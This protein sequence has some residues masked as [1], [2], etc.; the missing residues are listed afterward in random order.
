MLLNNS[1][2]GKFFPQMLRQSGG[3]D[4]QR[5]LALSECIRQPWERTAETLAVRLK[6]QM[7]E[8]N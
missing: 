3:N 1:G 7:V 2:D 8:W 6:T 5:K 4:Q